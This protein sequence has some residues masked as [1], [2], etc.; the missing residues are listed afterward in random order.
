MPEAAFQDSG[1]FRIIPSLANALSFGEV[2]QGPNGEAEF[3]PTD[4][5]LS[6]GDSARMRRDGVCTILKTSGVTLLDGQDWFWD[7]SEGKVVAYPALDDRDFWGGTANGD[8]ASTAITMSGHLN[9]RGRYIIDTARDGFLFVP[10]G[11]ANSP[12]LIQVGGWHKLVLDATN[13]A[14]KVDL[15]S[16]QGFSLD[17]NWIAE[18]EVLINDDGASAALDF[19]CGVANATDSDNA[20]DITESAFFHTDGNTVDIL[21]ESDDGTNEVAATDTTI[22]YTLDTVW[23]GIIDGRNPSS[24]AYY[25]NGS[26]VLS[27]TTFNI[28]DATGPLKLLIHLEKSAAT[29]TA[30][31]YVRG[32]VRTMEQ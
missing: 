29:D 17:S 5:A 11:T 24:L 12:K 14:Q 8:A 28:E 22:D 23:R 9:R 32:R 31:F 18:F 13:E 27:G 6:S 4:E 15:L 26:R 19:N 7:R 2:Y 21:A 20:D 10:V 30:V 1:N 25:I 16:M 3:Y